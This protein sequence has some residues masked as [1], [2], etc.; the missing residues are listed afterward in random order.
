MLRNLSKTI[1]KD[2]TNLQEKAT[3]DA[4]S[5]LDWDSYRSKP[6]QFFTTSEKEKIKQHHLENYKS[7]QPKDRHW[8]S[9]SKEWFN[10]SAIDWDSYRSKPNQFFTT[11]DKEKIIKQEKL[12]QYNTLPKVKTGLVQEFFD[13]LNIGNYAFAGAA[14]GAVSKDLGV[15]E[16]FW[17]GLTQGLTILPGWEGHRS[18]ARYS[19]SETLRETGMKNDALVFGLGLAMDIGLD[20]MTYLGP[21]TLGKV[22]KGSGQTVGSVHKGTKVVSSVNVGTKK[23]KAFREVIEN[24]DSVSPT[25]LKNLSKKKKISEGSFETAEEMVKKFYL[26]GSRGITPEDALDVVKKFNEKNNIT[27]S[28]G[29]AMSDA[30]WFSDKFNKALGVPVKRGNVTFGP[31]NLPFGGKL[32]LPKK[33]II[34]D[35]T[36]RKLGDKT[37]APYINSLANVIMKSPVGK[38]F[39]TKVD[40]LKIAERSPLEFYTYIKL[41]SEQGKNVAKGGSHVRNI[42]KLIRDNFQDPVEMRKLN[43]ALENP[44]LKE[45]VFNDKEFKKIISE[46]DN[47][48]IPADIQIE[49]EVSKSAYKIYDNINDVIKVSL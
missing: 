19:Y 31:G 43:D 9:N 25:V 45:F 49:G 24:M 46:I 22:L 44:A 3:Q 27:Y 30:K 23:A 32:K 12:K 41:L 11:S 33:D 21:G 36:L 7:T 29:E 26:G 47:S 39:S 16:G 6:N 28:L 38:A 18:H 20:P 15:L 8:E 40:L 10:E 35:T 4:L 34:S 5:T 13:L 17:R 14:K 2:T 42:Q 1:R 37:V 48:V